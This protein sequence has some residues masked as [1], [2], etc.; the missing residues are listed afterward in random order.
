[1]FSGSCAKRNC[2]L[3]LHTFIVDKVA[4][5][6]PLTLPFIPVGFTGLLTK[7]Y[8]LQGGKRNVERQT[9]NQLGGTSK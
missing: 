4:L 8:A 5:C 1:M 2:T 9:E 6:I 3:L 7:E